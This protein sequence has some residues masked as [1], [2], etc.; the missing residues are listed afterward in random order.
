MKNKWRS[1][2]A[3]E[4]RKLYRTKQWRHLRL[5]ALARDSYR[6]QRCNC[7]L[8]MGRTGNQAAVVHHIKAHKGDLDLF[9]DVNNLQSV[10]KACHDGPIQ[11]EEVRGF[12]T[13]IGSDGWPT[14][15]NHTGN[16]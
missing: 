10:C 3:E 5:V 9:F 7:F 2:E 4:Y 13:D 8:R 12:S 16:K 15:P 11:S 1:P 6:C 14:D